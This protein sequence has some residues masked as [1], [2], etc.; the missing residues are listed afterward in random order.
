[1]TE[2]SQYAPHP[3]S[4]P[5]GAGGGISVQPR[6]GGFGAEI[7]GIDLSAPLSQAQRTAVRR[8]WTDHSVVWFPDQKLDI[9]GL[10]RF[11]AQMGPFGEDP[12]ILPMEDHPNV[13]ELRREPD[14]TAK[15]FGAGWHSDWS[16]QEAPPAATLLLA[17]TVPPVGGDTLFADTYAAY[18]ALPPD[19]REQLKSLRAVHSAR[20]PY[21][22][23]GLYANEA[24]PRTMKIVTGAAAEATRT[25]P[26]IRTH[27]VSGREALYV[28]PIYTVGLEGHSEAAA[29]AILQPLFAHMLED[30]FIYRHQWR[31]DMLTMW[32]NRCT[33]HFADGGYDGH[34]RVMYRTTVAGE[35][36]MLRP[37]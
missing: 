35:A 20:R 9:A 8:A 3:A 37:T 33:M 5:A 10:E 29:D 36:P 28:N 21:G 18:E 6:P 2:Q 4:A 30:R 23:D 11:T 22:R 32:D 7:S 19:T 15:N 1:M 13:L 25:H 27:P 16:F 17:K 12:F 31:P 14:E 26:V 34:L 24:D